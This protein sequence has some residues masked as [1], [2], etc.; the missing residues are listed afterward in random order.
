[1]K[2][3]D[4]DEITNYSLGPLSSNISEILITGSRYR[5]RLESILHAWNRPGEHVLEQALAS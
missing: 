5:M 3:F 4:C 1:M 2:N